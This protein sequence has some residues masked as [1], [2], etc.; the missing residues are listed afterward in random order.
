MVERPLG[1]GGFD[2]RVGKGRA[3]DQVAVRPVGDRIVIH[4]QDRAEHS[5]IAHLF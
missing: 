2:D 3:L 4:Q 1:V 5:R